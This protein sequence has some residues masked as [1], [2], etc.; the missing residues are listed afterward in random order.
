[1]SHVLVIEDNWFSA[2]N[3]VE[4]ALQAG[5]TS[6]SMAA[7]QKDAV[8][9]A[10]LRWPD[11]ILSDVHLREGTGTLAVQQIIDEL[12]RVPVIFITAWPERCKPC[13][14]PTV[15]LTKPVQVSRFAGLFNNMLIGVE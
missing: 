14:P 3:N 12:G 6:C 1:M 13:E 2:C 15:V 9:Q 7:T 10:H 11:I 4:L 5:A 8:A